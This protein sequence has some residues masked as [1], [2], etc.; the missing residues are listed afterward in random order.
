MSRG[1]A[2]ETDRQHQRARPSGAVTPG[3]LLYTY[4]VAR[5]GSSPPDALLGVADAPV[6]TVT[7]GGLTALVSEVPAADFEEAALRTRLEDLAWLERTARAHRSVVDA[8]AAL[9]C[10][11]PLRL[12]TVHR[13]ADG[14]RAA[15]SARAGNFSRALAALDGRAEWGVKAYASQ[16]QPPS[17]NGTTARE[18]RPADRDPATRRP[19]APPAGSEPPGPPS[20]TPTGSGRDFLRRRLA[21]RRAREESEQRA[22][23]LV[24]AAHAELD[25][26]AERSTLHRP[27]DARLS[28]V[29]DRN[30]LN[31]AYLLPRERAGAFAA[32][33]GEL[34]ERSP[35]V[36]FELTGPWAPYSFAQPPEPADRGA[37]D[38]TPTLTDAP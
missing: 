29:P 27:Q 10:V 6:H 11:L 4:A 28:G 14:V 22:D 37:T 8:A 36:R 32:L 20:G 16:E 25:R 30:L 34:D 38:P 12:V 5:A 17:G 3:R 24:R 2:P 33:V 19:D 31:G 9:F 13:D 7:E 21:Q 35:G 18:R 26:F 15:L 23:A 1:R